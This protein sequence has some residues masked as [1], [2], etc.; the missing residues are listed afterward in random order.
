MKRW[1]S[2]SLTWMGMVM[3]GVLAWRLSSDALAL[4]AGVLVGMLAMSPTLFLVMWLVRQRASQEARPATPAYPPIIVAGGMPMSLPQAPT[5]PSSPGSDTLP[6]PPGL[7]PGLTARQWTMRVY[8]EEGAG[9]M[10][11]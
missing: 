10:D 1:L 7:Q 2:I 4:I 3:V 11:G 5:A 9:N 8:G 6:P